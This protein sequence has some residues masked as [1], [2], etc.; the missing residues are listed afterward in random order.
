[1]VFLMAVATLP[2][3]TEALSAHGLAGDTPAA[4]IANGTTSMQRVVRGT[5]DDIAAIVEAEDIVPPAITVIG[6][7]AALDDCTVESETAA[8]GSMYG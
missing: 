4:T 3:I 7:V 2:K 6:E 8:A 5:L 1:M